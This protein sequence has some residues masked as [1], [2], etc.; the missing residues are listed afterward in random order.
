MAK[1]EDTTK[2]TS[3]ALKRARKADV[4]TVRKNS[5]SSVIAGQIQ[6]K[7]QPV[8][9]FL[10]REYNLPVPDNK[11]GRLLNKKIR[12]PKYFRESWTEVKKVKFPTRREAIRLTI[13]VFVFSGFFALVTALADYGLT[14]AVERIILK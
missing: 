7:W 12:A 13:A 1:K 11:I 2:K 10:G 8:K 4:I 6:T 3:R 14:K 9:Q 5:R